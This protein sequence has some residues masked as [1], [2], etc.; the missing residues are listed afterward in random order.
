MNLNQKI[1]SILNEHKK[2]KRRSS[3]TA[4]LSVLISVLVV[5]N[6][7]M[8]AISMSISDLSSFVKSYAATP[9]TP[10]TIAG[11]NML[12][13]MSANEW[14]ATLAANGTYFY[15][16][17]QG[18]VTTNT[19]LKTNTDILTMEGYIAYKFSQDVKKYLEGSGPHL[20]WDL[21]NSNLTAIFKDQNGNIIDHG[22]VNDPAYPDGE[23]GIFK[24]EGGCVKVTL[25][26]GYINYVKSG[27]GDGTIEGSLNFEGNLNS[28]NDESGDQKFIIN[29][30]EVVID[31]PDKWPTIDKTSWVNESNGTIE[32]TIEVKNPNYVALDTYTLTDDML[33]NAVGDVTILPS[34]AGRFEN[35]QIAF[36]SNYKNGATIKYVT[37]ITEDQMK[38]V[39]GSQKNHAELKKDNNKIAEDDETANLW[40]EP[41]TVTKKGTPDYQTPGGSYSKEI[42]WEITIKNEYGGSLEDYLIEDANIPNSGVEVKPNGSLTNENGKWKLTGTGDASSVTIKYTTNAT[43]GKNQNTATLY[44][45]TGNPTNKEGKEEVD[46]E[47]KNA[48]I[49]LQKTAR[50]D[51]TTGQIEWTITIDNQN[52]MDLNGYELSDNML[53]NPVPGSLSINPTNAA[54]QPDGNGVVT[55]TDETKN[56][57]WITIKYN[58]ALTPE[59]LR[60]GEA[61]NTAVLKDPNDPENPKKSPSDPTFTKNPFSIKKTGEPDYKS[62]TYPDS[63]NKIKWKIEVQSQNGVSLE[64]YIIKDAKIPTDLSPIKTSSGTL[65]YVS[66]ENWKLT[67]TGDAKYITIEYDAPVS[68]TGGIGKENVNDVELK[69]P[70]DVTTGKTDEGKVT[71]KSKSDLVGLNKSGN[72]IQDSHE[73][74]WTIHVTVEGGYDITDYRLYDDMFKNVDL[75]DIQINDQPASNFATLDK[76]TGILTFTS[77]PNSD[78]FNIT[79]KT[80][81]DMNAP[82]DPDSGKIPVSNGYGP[83][84]GTKTATVDVPVREDLKKQLNPPKGESVDHSGKLVR[85]LNW[86]AN[87]THDG[88]FDGLIYVDKLTPPANGTHTMTNDQFAA[89]KVYGKV[90]EYDGNRTQLTKGADYELVPNL[91]KTGFTINFKN[92]L[93][94]KGYNFVD[95]EYQTTATSN[96][97]VSGT[98]YPVVSEFSNDANFN[99]KHVSDKFTL[100]RNDPEIHT[101]LN[102]HLT[103]NWENDDTSIRPA[104][105]YFKVLYH[106]GDYQ[107]KSVKFASDG[108]YLFSGD[109][110]YNSAT[111]LLTLNGSGDNWSKTLEKLPQRIRTANADGAVASDLTYYYK[112]EEVKS[113]GSS[114]ENNLLHVNGGSYYEV[115]YTN[116]NGVGNKDDIYI[117]ANNKLHRER[118]I[119]PQ[120]IWTGDAGTGTGINSITVQ[121]EY[122][123]DNYNYYPVR[124][125]ASGEYVF[126]QSSTD[127]IVTQDITG[128]G[129]NWTGTAWEHLPQIIPVGNGSATCQYRIREIKYNDIEISG[130][131]FIADGGYYNVSYSV[132]NGDLTVANDYKANKSISYA[133]NKLWENDN[134]YLANRP[135][136]ILVKLKQSGNDGTTKYY[137]D[138]E[139]VTELNADNAWKH[140][141]TGLPSQSTNDGKIVTYTYTAEEVGYVKDGSTINIT[142][143]YFATTGDGW[144]NIS[145]DYYGTPNNTTIKNTFEPVTTIAITPQKKWV[146]DNE[147]DTNSNQ[148]FSVKNRPQNVTLKLQRRLDGTGEWKDVPVSDTD[149]TPVTVQLSSANLLEDQYSSDAVWQGNAIGNLP[150]TIVTFDDQGTSTKHDC[151]YRLIEWKYTPNENAKNKTEVTLTDDDVSF[152]T[153]DGKYTISFGSTS[154]SGNFEVINTFEESIGVDKSILDKDGNQLTSIDMEDLSKF[155]KEIDGKKYYVFNYL[156]EYDSNKTSLITPVKDILPEGFTLIE[157]STYNSGETGIDWNSPIITPLT[158]LDPNA[159]SNSKKGKDGYY[160][161]PCIIWTT[162]NNTNNGGQGSNYIKRE[163]S[164]NAAWEKPQQSPSRYYYDSNENAIYFG[165]PSI[166]TV[167]VFTY[168]IKIE[169]TK[170]NELLNNGSYSIKNTIERYNNDQTPT[171]QSDSATLKI[172][173]KTPKDLIKKT[174]EGKTNI[175]GYIKYAIDVNP[176]GKNLSTGDTIDIQDLLDAVGYYDHDYKGGE[177]TTG[178]KL[179]DILMD[180]IKLYEVDANGNMVPLAENQY[181]RVFKNGDQVSNG[182][183]L[184]QLTIPDETH[185]RVEYTYKMIANENTPSVIHGCKSS[186]YVNGRKAIMQPG[187]VPPEGDSVT[188]SNKAELIADSAS[189]ESEVTNTQYD[190]FKSY[191]NITTNKLPKIVKVN[192]GNYTINTLKA[193]FLLAKYEDGKWYYAISINDGSDD[194]KVNDR[195]ITWSTTGVTG[196]QIP[197]GDL[198]TID[199]QT[200]YEVALGETVLYKLIEIQVPEGYEGSNLGLEGNGFKELIRNYLNSGSTYYDGKDYAKFLHNYVSTYYFSYNSIISERPAD[201]PADKVIQVKSGD[202]LK[203]PNNELI[204][205]DIKKEW[206]NPT[207]ST[208]NSEIT[209]ELYWSYVKASSGMPDEKDLHLAKAEDLG[210]MDSNFTA[211]KTIPIEYNADGSVKTNEK[212]WENLPNGKNSVPIYYYIKETGY[213]IGGK[214][215]TLDKE[216]GIFKTASGE[217]GSYRPTYVGN[218]ANSD[219]TINVRNSNQLMLKKSWKNSANVELKNIPVDKVVVSIYG[220]DGDGAETLLFENITLSEKNKWQYDLTSLI[221]P[222]MEL[223][224][225]KSFVAKE[226]EDSSLEDFVVS[227]VFNLNEET[228]EIIVTNK[229]TVPTEASVKVDKVWSDGK[230]VH[231]NETIHVSLYQS[232]KKIEDL[233]NLSVKLNANAKLMQ[234]ID[235][236]DKQTYE[237][238][239]LNAEND[240][241]YTWIG[242]PLEDENQNKYYYYVLEDKSGIANVNKYTE[243]Y[244]VVAS[245]P[246]KTDYTITNTR[247]AI[248]VQKKWVDE[249]GYVIPDD[250]LTQGAITLDVLKKVPSKPE[251]GI[252][253]IA[254]GDSITEG[255]NGGGLDCNKNGEDYPSKLVASL[256]KA[257]YTIKN[258]SNVGD[259]NKGVST[260]Q[261]GAN[262]TDGFRNRV[263]TDIPSDTDIVCFIGGTNDIHQTGDAKGDPQEVY[264]RFEACIGEIMAQ[265]DN[266]AIIFVGSIPHFDFYRNGTITQGGSWW[267]DSKYTENDGKYAN[268][269]IDEYNKKIKAY[270][271]ATPNVYFVD[272]C[273]VVKDEYIRDDGCHPNE[274]GYTAIAAVFQEAIDSTYNQTA[275]VGEITLTKDNGWVG[276]FDI[277]DTDTSAEYYIE[278]SRVPQ[279]WQVSYDEANRYQ[280]IGS[281]TPLVA[282]N[283]RHIPKTSLNVEK[284]WAND[285]GGEANRE[286]ISLALLQS[287]DLKNW[288]EY[289]TPMP[290]PDKPD[291][292]WTYRYTDL[293]AEDNAGNRYYYKIE[294]APMAGYTTSYG[295]PSYLTAVNDSNAGTLH[296]TNTAAVSLKLRK[297]WS[298]IDT[299]SHLNDQVTFKIYRAVKSEKDPRPD[300][301]ESTLILEV[302][303]TEVGVTVDSTVQVKANKPIEIVQSEGSE[304]FFTAFVKDGKIIHVEGKEEGEGTITVTDGTDEITVH[305]TVSAYKLLLDNDENFT[306]TAGEQSHKLSVTKG[307]TAFTDVTYSSSNADVLTVGTDGTITTVNAGTATVTVATGG[308]VIRTQD[309]IVNVP[310]T[311]V[312]DSTVVGGTLK[313]G[314]ELTLTPN[315]SFGKF[316]YESDNKTCATVNNNG[317]VTA[318]GAGTATITAT[319]TNWDGKAAGE[320]TYLVTVSAFKPIAVDKTVAVELPEDFDKVTGISVTI[321]VDTLTAAWYKFGIKLGKHADNFNWEYESLLNGTSSGLEAG[322]TYTYNFN[323]WTYNYG[324]LYLGFL[325]NHNG[326]DF[327]YTIENIVYTY[328]TPLTLRTAS[329]LRMQAAGANMR[330]GGIDGGSSS[331]STDAKGDYMTV[332]LSGGS[333]EGWETIIENLDVYASNENPYVYWVEEVAGADSYEANYQFSDGNPDSGSWIDSSSPN[334]DGELVAIVRNTKTEVPGVVMPSTGS[335][336]TR[337]YTA[338]GVSIM[339]TSTAVYILT[340]RR[341]KKAS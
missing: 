48:L 238:V 159:D 94:T 333:A 79:Y 151:D 254:F 252:K 337:G 241:S 132:V 39:E 341:R 127:A 335:T 285:T 123:A 281:S 147:T 330:A 156:I 35:G 317:V 340:K 303:K 326:G 242:L 338:A 189:D 41:F 131:Q 69:Y 133:V 40:K 177:N 8:P 296:I 161:S 221:T 114:I 273:S 278:E 34:D 72:Y 175:P 3:A 49:N 110:G 92:T 170:L 163:S 130:T 13:L 210:I 176:E 76:S 292:V 45:P 67:N 103:K 312:L 327:T 216:D 236:N 97:V 150:A 247:Q 119:T 245:T 68:S 306:I 199:V 269:L 56:A 173:N 268:G 205:L 2:T 237:N 87:I 124:K 203:I 240:W 284:T 227:C 277:T 36:D 196:T 320:E 235:E 310:N 44:Y 183:A 288:V 275:K 300:F 25:T 9:G 122:T 304:N 282:T 53:K 5:S 276:A 70:D 62:G 219:T 291:S 286:S 266:K 230:S 24:I 58:T 43:D 194:P 31:F 134:A 167:P 178:S 248:V 250:Q 229:N 211:T 323:T 287:T 260:Q 84:E 107:W 233:T 4:F 129:T 33:K 75:S 89:V 201:V 121:L 315:P 200:A 88:T 10:S 98:Q 105:A 117:S 251:D 314:Q 298:D 318:V 95:I 104:N 17:N 27:D 81:V 152:K 74:T 214:T 313:V 154:S 197:D 263:A 116:N 232:T 59:Q 136:K 141:W 262:K 259:F 297:V 289:D 26:E 206:V 224:G 162:A 144:Y 78:N 11:T 77:K 198:K 96:A 146:G 168:S 256:T 83:G 208:E 215:Y 187:F 85:T 19:S 28:S 267:S 148:P 186:T 264:R 244:A 29:G 125:N 93:D 190:V 311:F 108:R 302:D 212:V 158:P 90:S 334:A 149:S 283:T 180:D 226:V 182:A 157:N 184:L 174:Y 100:T 265:T 55:L 222:D 179:V 109:N 164:V 135:E 120:K 309:I 15:D 165:V 113:D 246:T 207:T 102:L 185:I 60:A 321:R 71:Y 305:V 1:Q 20:G 280:K 339:V 204:D 14:N 80:K 231:A 257:G 272:V 6:L 308:N 271:E 290:V 21:G 38:K 188:F 324:H 209:A 234:P 258:G 307:G 223:S 86:T 111:E 270:A 213:T 73:I 82:T 293:P 57:K 47:K 22:L 328:T 181:T 301:D 171:K 253:L 243:S 295:T 191:G 30:Q 16:A 195:V 52:G 23:A 112:V 220:V 65:V 99:G 54:G 228:G 255:Y 225:Y 299:N 192:T 239:P 128:T 294:E 140:I 274:E 322:K 331:W 155:E 64:N 169:C 106:T 325:N 115:G 42:N 166:S 279:G 37:K 7:I 202:D 319:R 50:V 249:Q 118:S 193:N 137:P 18:G 63:N 139:T 261:I 172:I 126:D 332:T 316:E 51:T 329:P 160:L 138:E 32:W 218:A 91:N 336:G 142:Q 153:D 145:Y 143:N 46:Y 12:D 66:G 101:I 217:T 61:S